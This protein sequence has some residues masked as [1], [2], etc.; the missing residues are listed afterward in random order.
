MGGRG[1]VSLGGARPRSTGTAVVSSNPDNDLP[2]VGASTP[3]GMDA[4]Y[5]PAWS[6]SESRA[7]V[8]RRRERLGEWPSHEFTSTRVATTKMEKRN[9]EERIRKEKKEKRRGKR[10][11]NNLMN[12]GS[13]MS[14]DHPIFNVPKLNRKLSY[15]SL[16]N[17]TTLG[18]SRL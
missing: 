5:L 2:V 6:S 14:M 4:T 18:S 8:R 1:Q 12:D 15:S 11:K 7:A 13:Y 16:L 10:K 17:E 3:S 9:K